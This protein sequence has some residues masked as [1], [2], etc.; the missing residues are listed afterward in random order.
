MYMGGLN[1]RKFVV[2]L[3]L[4]LVL[5]SFTV[6][7]V[8]DLKLQCPTQ[9][10]I[11]DQTITCTLLF[12]S[13]QKVSFF[14]GVLTIP[15]VLSSS[16]VTVVASGSQFA[17]YDQV[18]TSLAISYPTGGV[19]V[20]TLGTVTFKSVKNGDMSLLS[21]KVDTGKT[22][23]GSSIPIYS[24]DPGIITAK[25]GASGNLDSGSSPPPPTDPCNV[26]ENINTVLSSD[27]SKYCDGVKGTQVCSS[28]VVGVKF[29][30][31]LD[32]NKKQFV[33][34]EDFKWKE[35]F[36]QFC[37]LTS[38]L[39]SL[40]LKALI[41]VDVGSSSIAQATDVAQNKAFSQVFK[42]KND[43]AYFKYNGKVF[44]V[45]LKDVDQYTGKVTVD[46]KSL[47]GGVVKS[48][49]P[50]VLSVNNKVLFT[51]TQVGVTVDEDGIADVYLSL[52]GYF[53]NDKDKTL[54][55]LVAVSPKVNL[56]TYGEGWAI[57]ASQGV[58]E[59][60]LNGKHS[61]SA[62][63]QADKNVVLVFDGQDYTQASGN[64]LLDF[65]QQVD[66]DVKDVSSLVVVKLSK[67]DAVKA[68]S[69]EYSFTKD[70]VYAPSGDVSYR[71]CKN[72]A[73][74]LQMVTVC[75]ADQK[76]VFSLSDK[77]VKKVVI[78]PKGEG[79]SAGA[80]LFRYTSPNATEMKKVGVFQL[81]D[82][83]SG[84]VNSQA[85][86]LGNNLVSGKRLGLD[87]WGK[88]YLLS[89]PVEPYLD[90]TKLQLTDISTKEQLVYKA[91]GDQEGVVFNLPLGKQINI[92]LNFKTPLGY[93][94]S[95]TT[96]VT[97]TVDVEKALHT[98]F[99]TYGAV[100]LHNPDLGDV[101]VSEKDIKTF[102]NAMK[103]TFN[104]KDQDLKFGVPSMV[105]VTGKNVL[106]YYG[107]FTS[108]GINTY[109]KYADAYL[110]Y[111]LG[112]TKG[113]YT[114][115]FTDEN[116]ILPLVKGNSVAF[117]L[118]KEYYLLGYSEKWDPTSPASG[119]L[120]EKLQLTKLGTKEVVKAMPVVGKT[121]V[122]FDLGAREID[123]DVDYATG[124]VTFVGKTAVEKA[125]M[126][127]D[128]GKEYFMTLPVSV[129]EQSE[130]RVQWGDD[131]LYTCDTKSTAGLSSYVLLCGSVIEKDNDKIAKTKGDKKQ[132][133]LV[134]KPKEFG[135][136]ADT[137]LV[138]YRENGGSGKQITVQKIYAVD[139]NE[140][141]FLWT[142]IQGNLLKQKYP[143]LKFNGK[144][145][146]LQGEKDLESY[147]LVKIPTSKKYPI[148]LSKVEEGK[149]EGMIA[150]DSELFSFVQ[151]LNTDYDFS[152]VMKHEEAQL[153][154]GGSGVNVTQYDAGK[155]FVPQL[156][157]LVYLL[158]LVK[159]K[160][161][162]VEKMLSWVTLSDEK[163][164]VYYAGYLPEKASADV[165]LPDG[166]V[167]NVYMNNTH[168]VPPEKPLVR[169]TS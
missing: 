10:V 90:L 78:N 70:M 57:L 58:Q 165:L 12:Q 49:T 120:L 27:Q 108:A 17:Q 54:Q 29:P 19:L 71:V 106:L 105:L 93:D 63:V 44:V 109:V 83:S 87:V 41:E 35:C 37:P 73:P 169:I 137:V 43:V 95:A 34:D 158:T 69:Y 123:V 155:K 31:N 61:I 72:D 59:F 138:W 9:S 65:G 36:N 32:K 160:V 136:G 133:L 14:K 79:K 76:E 26:K 15:S 122:T 86:V 118:E 162:E 112:Q 140:L 89:H 131:D 50:L 145:Y 22:K 77:V 121:A 125:K 134:M 156:G 117:K 141:S 103:I 74:S 51:P 6:L 101:K 30:T 97:K 52:Y 48:T 56:D 146:E 144:F 82:I 21:L 161:N 46:V 16:D 8:P 98:S 132:Q 24:S 111:D 149:K 68:E 127:F 104:S 7:A 139:S 129:P 157:S 167:V 116:F 94:I 151:S 1:F 159:G 84:T 107:T 124:I 80:M 110:F 28:K 164:E 163:G 47:V 25:F 64:A 96:T 11:S 13:A 99:S 153:A 85:T 148:V 66:F 4:A 135:V 33:C 39:N 128:A 38:E 62:G 102:Q 81:V 100:T 88:Y 113:G 154:S 92:K 20:T 115:E 150:V 91:E 126:T 142:D 2:F 40:I 18:S 147:A 143:V 168:N 42:S 55:L 53:K 45:G 3:G 60:V 152:L 5:F 67:A 75:D 119:F 130:K 166:S 114:H 23:D